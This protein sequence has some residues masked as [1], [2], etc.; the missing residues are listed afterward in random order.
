[1]ANLQDL[2]LL[3]SQEPRISEPSTY[4]E[5][6]ERMQ[7]PEYNEHISNLAKWAGYDVSGYEGVKKKEDFTEGLSPQLEQGLEPQNQITEGIQGASIDQS[8]TQSELPS[9]LSAPKTM[10]MPSAPTSIYGQAPQQEEEIDTTTSLDPQNPNNPYDL[11]TF[12]HPSVNAIETGRKTRKNFQDKYSFDINASIDGANNFIKEENDMAKDMGIEQEDAPLSEVEDVQEDISVVDEGGKRRKKKKEKEAE[13]GL[14]TEGKI[15]E[16]EDP[17]PG[18]QIIGVHTIDQTDKKGRQK[19]QYIIQDISYGSD[20]ATSKPKLMEGVVND[21]VW[22]HIITQKRDTVFYNDDS[23]WQD[24]NQAVITVNGYEGQE[25]P[26]FQNNLKKHRVKYANELGFKYNDQTGDLELQN[27][28]FQYETG[29]LKSATE[30]IIS[31]SPKEEEVSK[32]KLGKALDWVKGKAKDVVGSVV[33][34]VEKETAKNKVERNLSGQTRKLNDV[35]SNLRNDAME[36]ISNTRY[37]ENIDSDF[38]RNLEVGSD[39]KSAADVLNLNVKDIMLTPEKDLAE[40]IKQSGYLNTYFKPKVT[41]AVEGG[42]AVA[43]VN[44]QEQEI[45]PLVDPERYQARLQ[46]LYDQEARRLA[47]ELQRSAR[48]VLADKYID[49]QIENKVP[50]FKLEDKDRLKQIYNSRL[51]EMNP[52]LYET[53]NKYGEEGTVGWNEKAKKSNN[54]LINKSDAAFASTIYNNSYND[55]LNRPQAQAFIAGDNLAVSGVESDGESLKIR[56]EYLNNRL[57]KE[58]ESSG[59]SDDTEVKSAIS[60]VGE[61][62][63]ILSDLEKRINEKNEKLN[64]LVVEENGNQYYIDEASQQE[65]EKLLSEITALTNEYNK[66]YEGINEP[67]SVLSR[68]NNYVGK[69][70]NLYKEL[71]NINSRLNV[72]SEDPNIVKLQELQQTLE[73]VDYLDWHKKNVENLLDQDGNVNVETLKIKAQNGEISNFDAIHIINE[74]ESKYYK[75]KS[76]NETFWD[77][78]NVP[79]IADK[80]Y[81]ASGVS[82]AG[83][84]STIKRVEG[85][86]E[87]LISYPA[88][89]LSGVEVNENWIN[90]DENKWTL[91][92]VEKDWLEGI[93]RSMSQEV[94]NPAYEKYSGSWWASQV[95]MLTPDLIGA[96][97]GGIGAVKTGIQSGFV[98]GLKNLA[99]GPTTAYFT[100]RSAG[101][102]A[103]ELEA[104]GYSPAAALAFGG[105][106]AYVVAA[107]ES[108][109]PAIPTF[110]RVTLKR[111]ANQIIAQGL[112]EGLKLSEIAGRISAGTLRVTGKSLI[113]ILSHSAKEGVIEEGSQFIA[114]EAAMAGLGAREIE[115]IDPRTGEFGRSAKEYFDNVAIGGLVGGL[116]GG[117]STISSIFNEKLRGLNQTQTTLAIGQ[118]YDAILEKVLSENKDFKETKSYKEMQEIKS[119]YDKLAAN[120]IYN[121]YDDIAKGAILNA[122]VNLE[123]LLK[124]QSDFRKKGIVNLS[125]DNQI[126]SKQQELNS[127]LESADERLAQRTELNEKLNSL[128]VH[129]FFLN[130]DGSAKNVIFN[131]FMDKEMMKKNLPEVVKVINDTYKLKPTEDAV[132]KSETGQVPIQP[133]AAVSEQVEEGKSQTEPQVSAEEDKKEVDN[134]TISEKE[135]ETRDKIKNKNL[136]LE[137]RD[138]NGNRIIDEST[139]E[140]SQSVGEMISQNEGAAPVPTSVR[141]INGIEFVEFSNP[142]TGDLDVVVTG[143]QDGSYVGFYRIYENG[144]PTNKWSSKFENPS[145]NKDNFKTMI[146]GVQEMLP[147][148]HEYTEKSSISTDGLRVWHQQLSKGY[149]LQFDENGNVITNLVAIN[150]DA[151]V[152]ELGIPVEKGAFKNIKIN[153]KEDFEK[154]KNILLPYMQK[155]GLTE[156][157]IHYYTGTVKIDLPVLKKSQTTTDNVNLEDVKS[158][159]EL[160]NRDSNWDK[161]AKEN[162]PES[163]YASIEEFKDVISNGEW[164]MLTAENPMRQQLSDEENAQRN[165][166]AKAWLEERGYTP[167]NIF[168]KYDNSENSFFVPNLTKKDAIEFAKKFN[169]ES[170]ATNSGMVYQDGTYN[171]IKKGNETFGEK[172]NYYSTINIK[173]NRLSFSVD[174]DWDNTL[175]S[176]EEVGFENISDI[177]TGVRLTDAD[178]ILD[179]ANQTGFNMSDRGRSN[180]LSNKTKDG[181]K[182][183]IIDQAKRAVNTLK[184]LLP[185]FE[186]VVFDNE[187][188]YKDYARSINANPNSKGL[189]TTLGGGK[190]V[191][192]INLQSANLRTVAHELG[193][194]AL[195]KI[196]G[197]NPALFKEFKGKIADLAK[198]KKLKA[199]RENGEEF[200]ISLDEIAE[201]LASDKSYEDVERAEEYMSELTAALAQLNASDPSTKSFLKSIAEFINKFI[202]RYFGTSIKPIDNTSSPEEIME[203][204]QTLASTINVGGKVKY[205]ASDKKLVDNS[206]SSKAQSI[207]L[208]NGKE[209]AKKIGLIEKFNNVRQIAEAL[210]ARQRKKYGLIEKNDFSKEALNKISGWMFDEVKYF[211]ELMGD[212]SGKGWYGKQF[213]D[214]IDNMSQIFPELKNDQN[215]RDLF[216]MLVAIT[217]DGEKVKSNFRLASTAYSEYRETGRL[218]EQ[219][220][221][222]RAASINGNLAKIQNLLDQYKGNAS[223]LKEALLV[224]SSLSELNK[225]RRSQ[226]LENIKSNWP[227]T[228]E[229]PLSASIFGAKLGMF[230]ANL[231]GQEEYPTLDRWWSRTFNRYRGTLIPSVNRGFSSKGEPIGIDNLKALAGDPNMTDDQ[232][233]QIINEQAEN[234]KNKKYRNGT[235]LEKASNT[236]FK[237]INLNINDAPFNKSDRQF[238]YDAFVKTTDKL[239]KQGYDVSIADVQAILW[240]YEKH[241]YKTLGARGKIDGVSYGDVAQFIVDRYKQNNNSFNFNIKTSED[242]DQIEEEEAEEM[243]TEDSFKK[244]IFKPESNIKSKSQAKK[245]KAVKPD[246]FY[247]VGEYDV[248]DGDGN[249]FGR[250]FYDRSLKSWVNAE[251]YKGNAEP[252]TVKWIFGDIL[253][254]TKQEAIDELV[255]RRN[256]RGNIQEPDKERQAPVIKEATKE[257]IQN[258]YDDIKESGITVYQS[259]L[260]RRTYIV[261]DNVFVEMYPFSGSV[262]LSSISSIEKGRG[263]ASVVMKQIVNSADKRGLKMDLSAKAFGENGLKTSSLIDF[264]KKF[265]FEIDPNGIFAND[266]IEEIK[267][268]LDRYPNESVEMIRMPNTDIKSKA[269]AGKS[270]VKKS[271]L[272]KDDIILLETAVEE[273]VGKVKSGSGLQFILNNLVDQVRKLKSVRDKSPFRKKEIEQD[274]KNEVVQIV[275]REIAGNAKSYM[276]T[277]NINKNEAIDLALS[278]ATK[279]GI[280]FSTADEIKSEVKKQLDNIIKNTQKQERSNQQEITLTTTEKQALKDQIKKM[281][282]DVKKVVSDMKKQFSEKVKNEREMRGFVSSWVKDYL[283]SSGISNKLTPTQMR[284]IVNR[285]LSLSMTMTDKQLNNF[286]EYVDR[287]ASNQ[288]IADK[289]AELSSNR[290]GGLKRKHNQY[291]QQVK[292]FL[293]IPL[294]DTDGKMIF[295]EKEMSDYFDIVDMLNQN[296]PDHSM[297]DMTL[298]DKAINAYNEVPEDVSEDDFLDKLQ[299]IAGVE[300]N[301]LDD[302]RQFI[303]LINS[304]SNIVKSLYNKGIIDEVKRA[305]MLDTLYLMEDGLRIYDQNHQDQIDNLKR[306]II[307]NLSQ[308]IQ[309]V[310]VSGFIGDQK[311]LW[312]R[313]ETLMSVSKSEGLMKLD[314]KDLMKLEETLDRMEY[315]FMP[316][317]DFREIVNKAEVRYRQ[318]GKAITTQLKGL[319]GKMK[320]IV[321]NLMKRRLFTEESFQW[322]KVLGIGQDSSIYKY[323]IDPIDKGIRKMNTYTKNNIDKYYQEKSSIRKP[324]SGFFSFI[325]KKSIPNKPLKIFG[326]DILRYTAKV[327]YDTYYDTRV[328]VISHILDSGHKAVFFDQKSNDWLGKQLNDPVVRAAYGSDVYILDNIYEDLMSNPNFVTNGK[329]DYAKIYESYVNDPSSVFSNYE[330]S[331][332]E[333]F[334]KNV[335]QSGELIVNANAIR[336]INGELNPFH[337][338]RKYVGDYKNAAEADLLK[339]TFGKYGS[340][341]SG[342]SYT[343]VLVDPNGPLNFNI[344]Q[345]VAEQI[346][347][348]ARDY[349]LNDAISYTNAVI[350]NAKENTTTPIERAVLSAISDA[351]RKRV[352]FEISRPEGENI[353]TRAYN[354]LASAF[355]KKVLLPPKRL[356]TEL[357]TNVTSG[358]LRQR[359]LKGFNPL[360]MIEAKKIM[361]KFNSPVADMGWRFKTYASMSGGKLKRKSTLGYI[362]NITS[363]ALNIAGPTVFG[364]WM[365][366]FERHFYELTGERYNEEKH[367]DNP[368]Y[369][370]FLEESSAYANRQIG[371][372]RGGSLKGQTRMK[373]KV[374]PEIFFLPD[375]VSGQ[376]N[377]SKGTVDPNSFLGPIVNFFNNFVYRDVTNFF[378]GAKETAVG[379]V[380]LDSKKFADGIGSVFGSSYSL[381]IY[382][383]LGFILNQLWNLKFGDDEEKE[384]ANKNLKMFESKE[385]MT[386]FLSQIFTNL[387][388]TLST[389]KF[390]VSGRA[391]SIGALQYMRN[392]PSFDQAVIDEYLKTFYYVNGVDIMRSNAAEEMVADLVGI[393]SPPISDLAKEAVYL[394]QDL[395]AEPKYNRATIADIWEEGGKFSN[396]QDVV[397]YKKLISALVMT[398]NFGLAIK[399]EN[400]PMSRAL[401]NTLKDYSEKEQDIVIMSADGKYNLV[402][403]VLDFEDG[404]GRL[405]VQGETKDETELLSNKATELFINLVGENK[406]EFTELENIR[407]RGNAS[408]EEIREAD[409]FAYSLLQYL[410]DQARYEAKIEF[411]IQAK[412][413]SSPLKED[414]SDEEMTK[415]FNKIDSTYQDAI[416]KG[417]FSENFKKDM[418]RKER[419][420]FI[421]NPPSTDFNGINLQDI[422]EAYG[423]ILPQNI[424]LQRK[425]RQ[426]L[427]DVFDYNQG[428]M[429]EKPDY[430][431]YFSYNKSKKEITE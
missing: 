89:A 6:E 163:S 345:I 240:Y 216:T 188:D 423:K 54:F 220:A 16:Y 272:S 316:E 219:L 154:V 269:Q 221:S 105:G 41:E 182:S 15:E 96:A 247:F 10:E 333:L 372:I 19:Y 429:M 218:P 93:T 328:G 170:V 127:L 110:Q 204:F 283:K 380:R 262:H 292:K 151:I 302:Y 343:R 183:R 125:L 387:A 331:V 370:Y 330:N 384:K 313:F 265:G 104:A 291:T 155:L 57:N 217:S 317:A 3:L 230:Y 4:A 80:L 113:N 334:R 430:S 133:E 78:M 56:A 83:F 101:N 186:V 123:S 175:S 253:G 126:V 92:D 281:A 130:P 196:F 209:A 35:D 305:E 267:E 417:K 2:Y 118:D 61:I 167:E 365:A 38:Q 205:D 428:Y 425:V 404:K 257:D 162:L 386:E 260:D 285:A 55:F 301:N 318:M 103:E 319:Y 53:E 320:N 413:P 361:E 284:A 134:R 22:K 335:Q 347:E 279:S 286:I 337:S 270:N 324:K 289:M 20:K 197:E 51:D 287:I 371:K 152:N 14:P 194:A 146:S 299:E 193:H 190:G 352:D 366:N 120:E 77:W 422:K 374:V 406:S 13:G 392:D 341:R 420:E 358:A 297:L 18:V 382:P 298:A 375:A 259:P 223:K 135:Q 261:N 346:T 208:A 315:G 187:L 157:N 293:T 415:A 323:L 290:K 378:Y 164:G 142:D 332:Y 85:A 201:D 24:L 303:S 108:L 95:I 399:G 173:G 402:A 383:I 76:E 191:I 145:G 307:S 82:G 245:A 195:F 62:K 136:F 181:K 199:V 11:G 321:T 172:D 274:V 144:K 349:Y 48:Y 117:A 295:T 268:Y 356:V 304:A 84:F 107:M 241:L 88:E 138:E 65:G 359:T 139:G 97:G 391:V 242:I 426:Y 156:D 29:A 189:F 360:S 116:M 59:I 314:I 81:R 34:Y 424:G 91:V 325:P 353:L 431:D 9:F 43:A 122:S 367:L 210:E 69:A 202:A 160:P 115:I 42:T 124:A 308:K 70:G 47:K 394:T 224:K 306:E 237:V 86:V 388:M 185:N 280:E 336:G 385:Q 212:K 390:G 63:K 403:G 222:A 258:I 121:K 329:L 418:L 381:S 351:N 228:F 150:G 26:D 147:E 263:N 409:A 408:K 100:A 264:Y 400:L 288:K 246:D 342:S 397:D 23:M 410:A 39:I 225:K 248:V 30:G 27:P 338:P 148:N 326:R 396:D 74:A 46:E 357:I 66:V 114:E 159:R 273:A 401:V 266:S 184:S 28:E 363:S 33:G 256:Q 355:A 310:D 252:G 231:S 275:S 64:T 71:E 414:M 407:K 7:D 238:M 45:D 251:F 379:A 44:V 348:A 411:N 72:L 243:R 309:G 31:V 416:S 405:V 213:Q 362:E 8:A 369:Q 79:L 111:M 143:T 17:F 327:S 389:S 233:I 169:Q 339:G 60:K 140:E 300:I 36:L 215:A 376:L 412:E 373:Y 94:I 232:A 129:T 377:E 137:E 109:F 165:E 174:Y 226:G 277:R 49:F 90:E 198:G 427:D 282:S 340:I 58:K 87:T 227:A 250:I 296:I 200:E 398:A 178:A 211:I 99:T 171:P 244:S 25:K 419:E 393:V 344:D 21:K 112:K 141:E 249:Y 239:N 149:E 206:I 236:L 119:E 207:T 180:E 37:V 161:A 52:Y 177:D 67:S 192:A 229:A 294:F 234:Y 132:Q 128:G 102:Y 203:F 5:F 322:E 254:D 75:D 255:R 68:Y 276:D 179:L 32:S 98:A 153:S 1:M 12:F 364:E 278:D 421:A 368:E 395:I 176:D 271:D 73:A 166:E 350:Q 158:R 131:E 235:A 214:G 312:Q 50:S 168:G 106:I 311:N 40:R 354:N